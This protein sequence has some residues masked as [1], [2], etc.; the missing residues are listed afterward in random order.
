MNKEAMQQ[1]VD[2]LTHATHEK[3]EAEQMLRTAKADIFRLVLKE[4]LSHCLTVNMDA[5]RRTLQEK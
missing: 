5:V 3:M 2:A 1:A 4:G